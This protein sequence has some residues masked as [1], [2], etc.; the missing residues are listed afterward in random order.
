MN[1]WHW[2]IALL[3]VDAVWPYALAALLLAGGA[4]ILVKKRNAR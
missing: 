1:F 3:L 4:L 2:L